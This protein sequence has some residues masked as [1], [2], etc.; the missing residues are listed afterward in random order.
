MMPVMSSCL[1]HLCAAITATLA[2]LPFAPICAA[3]EAAPASTNW[4]AADD[5]KNMMQQLGITKYALYR[6]LH[7]LRR[8]G[9][10]LFVGNIGTAIRGRPSHRRPVDQAARNE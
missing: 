6:A 3:A 8:A 1:L 7:A 4:T 5:H 10:P 9:V 2:T